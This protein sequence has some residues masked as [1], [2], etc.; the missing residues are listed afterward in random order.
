LNTTAPSVDA[1]TVTQK[2]V[3]YVLSPTV[4]AVGF[5][6]LNL[7]YLLNAMDRQTFY[8]LLPSITKEYGFSLTESGFLATGFTIGMAIAG[9]PAGWIVDKLSRKSVLV[10]SI[11]IFSLGTALTPLAVGFADMA[12]YRIISGIGEGMQGAALYAAIGAYYFRRRAFAFAILN[13]AFGLGI[14]IGPIIG[15]EMA[16]ATGSWRTPLWVYAAIG[17]ALAACVLFA[18]RKEYTE[19]V[20]ENNPTP[21]D[22]FVNVPASRWNRNVILFAISCIV[23]GMVFYGFIGLYATYLKGQINFSIADAALATGIIGAGSAIGA[24]VSGWLG[25][26]V[27]QRYILICAFVVTAIVG[28]F[29]YHGVTSTAGQVWLALLMGVFASGFMFPNLSSALTRAVR[30]NH[31]GHGSGMFFLTYYAGAAFSGT[32]FGALAG[33]YGWGNAGLLQVT[34]FPIVGI[35]AL[36]FVKSN[37][38]IGQG[39]GAK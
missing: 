19:R 22:D 29:M 31:I 6:L 13:V 15:T 21:E 32:I 7:T 16:T 12:T 35:I 17:V 25:D 11:L 3:R 28:W 10:I 9:L 20:S 1:Q 8:P 33:A 30:P 24:L 2:K 27:Q 14:F 4:I 37:Q 26:R 5:V 23:A 39:G 34:L 38:L 36:C 18:V